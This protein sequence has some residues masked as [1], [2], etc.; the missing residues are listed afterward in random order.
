MTTAISIDAVNDMDRTAF[1]RAFGKIYEHSP[2]VAELAWA[3]RPFAGRAAIAD[4]M[5]LAVGKADRQQVL[6]L[7]RAHPRLG[8]LSSLT[9]QSHTEQ[10]S[11]GLSAAAASDREQLAR[12]NDAY[13]KKF[14]FP[15]IVSV[16]GMSVGEIIDA[17]GLRLERNAE[18]EFDECLRQVF[19]I[20]GFRLADRVAGNDPT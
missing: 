10:V 8:I 16:K 14:N 12:L 9:E 4:A 2:W 15:F 6:A 7:L 13:E 20:A 5:Q 18:S 1:V 11:A 17:C 3:S 19:R